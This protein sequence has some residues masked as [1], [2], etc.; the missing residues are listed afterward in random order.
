MNHY[1]YTDISVGQREQFAVTIT[2]AM[3]DRFFEI[4]QDCNPL[5]KEDSY[6]ANAGFD[7]RVVYGMLTA[8]FFSTLAGVYLPGEF[9]L[10]HSVETEFVKPVHIGDQLTITGLVK[11]KND[12][13]KTIELKITMT[14]Q[15][16]VKVCR[17]KM[18]V[19]L[20]K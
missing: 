19:G 14:N 15:N 1:Q 9:S 6:A 3:M 12:L 8:S 18:R 16:Q 4:T 2:E 7:G 17:G 20:Q 11:D 10:I 13:F 5:H